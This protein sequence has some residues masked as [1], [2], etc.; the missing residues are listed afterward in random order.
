MHLVTLRNVYD[1]ENEQQLLSPVR[2]IENVNNNFN[3]KRIQF[4]IKIGF[5]NQ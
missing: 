4:E 3:T 1:Y 2:N 5:S